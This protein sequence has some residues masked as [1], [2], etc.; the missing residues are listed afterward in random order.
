MFARSVLRSSRRIV[1][2]RF[3]ADAAKKGKNASK[4]VEHVVKQNVQQSATKTAPK[5][6]PKVE[7]PKVEVPKTEVPKVEVSKTEIPK[8]EAP[9]VETEVPKNKKTGKKS[10]VGKWTTWTLIASAGVIGT[11]SYHIKNDEYAQ[12]K[13]EVNHPKVMSTMR[14]LRLAPSIYTFDHADYNYL[15]Y[16]ERLAQYLYEDDM[17]H[18]APRPFATVGDFK[19]FLKNYTPLPE[20][21][22]DDQE[23]MSSQVMY[24]YLSSISKVTPDVYIYVIG[25]RL[26]N[27]SPMTDFALQE[28]IN[29]FNAKYVTMDG[30]AYIRM[31][32]IIDLFRD[33][34]TQ[35]K[36]QFSSSPFIKNF[37]NSLYQSVAPAEEGF[38]VEKLKTKEYELVSAPQFINYLATVCRQLP[39]QAIVM[40]SIDKA[41]EEDLAYGSEHKEVPATEPA[42]PIEQPSEPI[43]VE[44]KPKEE[45]I[46]VPE[47]APKP[48]E[49]VETVEPAETIT[50]PE[51]PVVEEKPETPASIWGFK[52]HVPTEG[53]K[54]N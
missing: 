33:M 53:W 38:L 4:K 30:K 20:D 15:T 3:F 16:I 50:V 28:G 40:A 27:I 47:P 17:E 18:K 1:N 35:S 5:A 37:C 46:S 48:V 31:K 39:S 36:A 34:E 54:L 7:I 8:A 11:Y 41:I 6:T 9:K 10:S 29:F 52:P 44:E 19:A 12:I 43:V 24:S 13:L 42:K 14:S 2:S 32:D 45:T 49:P 21:E 22:F 26:Y 25:E 23:L 51:T